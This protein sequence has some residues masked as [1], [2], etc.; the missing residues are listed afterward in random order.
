MVMMVMVMVMVI[1]MTLMMIMML[2]MMMMIKPLTAI[3]KALEVAQ[4]SRILGKIMPVSKN[5]QIVFWVGM[6]NLVHPLMFLFLKEEK[7]GG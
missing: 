2:M 6:L 7:K 5:K 3:K 4:G 1:M